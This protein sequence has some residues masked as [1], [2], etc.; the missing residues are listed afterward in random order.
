VAKATEDPLVGTLLDERYRVLER[1][2]T[3][4]MGSV[5]RAE[6]I[7]L[8]RSVAVKFLHPSLGNRP[9]FVERFQRE[10]M[11]MSKLYHVH[12]AAVHDMGVH[13]GSP[14]LVMEYIPGRTLADDLQSGALPPR[15]AILIM[16]Q[17]LEALRYLHR[18]NIVHRDLKPRN[19]MLVS[20]SGGS[21][22]V[23]VLDFGMAKLLTGERREITVQGT[24]VGTPSVMAPEQIR[25]GRVDGRTDIYA[26]GVMLYEM[27]VGH[28]PFQ[29]PDWNTLLRMQLEEMPRAPHEIVGSDA[30]PPALEAIIFRALAK[31]PKERFQSAEEMSNALGAALSDSPEIVLPA[32]KAPRRL[33]RAVTVLVAALLMVAAYLAFNHFGGWGPIN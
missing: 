11:A 30:C 10:A 12:C 17:V 6:R 28:K 13:Q 5:Y 16:R 1:L 21:D 7:T 26:A 3:G 29:H 4:G 18:R 20:S 15:R 9:A 32:P 31:E 2:G 22:F 24:I 25:Q 8:G 19:V 14:Y 23:K 33:R 27:V